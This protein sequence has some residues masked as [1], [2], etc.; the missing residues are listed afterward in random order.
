VPPCHRRHRESLKF[1]ESVAHLAGGGIGVKY[2]FEELV[3]EL[4]ELRLVA[5]GLQNAV[6]SV[7]GAHES[8]GDHSQQRVPVARTDRLLGHVLLD[9]AGARHIGS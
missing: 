9:A 2:K 7:W 6:Q 1:R 3:V 5:D 8:D 4:A